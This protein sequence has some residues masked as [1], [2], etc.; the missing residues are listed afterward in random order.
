MSME[1]LKAQLK[2]K[3]L[4]NLY[5]LF[6]EEGYLIRQYLDVLEKIIVQPGFESMNKVV[7]EGKVEAQA[8]IDNSETLPVFAEKK[9]VLVK[10][11]GFFGGKAK[12]G[13]DR[14]ADYFKSVP[15]ETCLVFVEQEVDKRIAPTKNVAKYGLVAEFSY[16]KPQ[17]LIGWVAQELKS[18]GRSIDK[19]AASQLV[20]YCDAGMTEIRNELEK[21]VLYTI[22]RTNVTSQDVEKV[23]TRSI[24]SKIFDLTDALSEKNAFKA[25]SVLEDMIALK[26]PVPRVIYMITRHLRTLLQAKMMVED[27]MRA[28]DALK[29]MGMHPFVAMKISKQIGKF[30][31]GL[32]KS[33]VEECLNMD[34]GI[35][36]GQ[37]EDRLAAELIIAKFTK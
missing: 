11:S 2:S 24:K 35:K 28:E 26:E 25:M 7:L 21:L 36:T 12:S 32:L 6:G 37:I 5:L 18:M 34:V 31:I 13:R 8:V 29:K 16:R 9:L 10:N 15:K 1:E 3:E 20:E 33:I 30:N 23:C 22:G 17:E 4:G 27:G 19:M 14:I